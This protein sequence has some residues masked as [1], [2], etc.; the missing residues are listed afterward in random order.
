LPVALASFVDEP[1]RALESFV[2][3]DN[4]GA[5]SPEPVATLD[6][7]PF[8]QSIK[9]IGSTIEPFSS[10]ALTL[11]AAAEIARDPDVRRR[12]DPGP[13]PETERI[14]TGE[15][16]LR[17]SPYGG[18]GLEH[19]TTALRIAERAD[20]TSIEGF[21]IAP[22]VKISFLPTALEERLRSL[23]WY[24]R[25]RGRFVQELRL[26]P[27]NVRFYFHADETI[28][29]TIGTLFDRFGL[30]AN[31][32][33]LAFER[34]FVRSAVAALT[35]FARTVRP[36][37]GSGGYRGLDFQDVWLDK[38]AVLAPDGTAFFVD[39]EGIDEVRVDPADLVEKYEDQV[40]RSLYEFMFAYEQIEG[41][42]SR[43]FG[44][45]ASRAAQFEAVAR[46]ALAGDP[47]VR[48]ARAGTSLTLKVESPKAQ[49][50]S[51]DFPLLDE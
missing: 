8:Y 7:L 13:T 10:R 43:R 40:Y 36:D 5:V 47:Y 21:R 39:L 49:G 26:V 16:W 20:L 25:F 31:G 29:G 51:L 23:Y 34:N 19:A 38:D 44:P 28:G 24:R 41:E 18:Q 12:L 14:I 9:G 2:A 37:P 45:P 27:S 35:L 3:D 1:A 17:G 48:L 50:L 15:L 42:R 33:A 6:G 46:A 11:A 4:R 22:V 30:T 32:A